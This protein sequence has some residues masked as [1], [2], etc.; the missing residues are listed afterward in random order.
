MSKIVVTGCAGFIGSHLVE[1]LLLQGREVIGIDNFHPYYQPSIKQNNIELALQSSKFEFHELS[2]LD[3]DKLV[4]VFD[5]AAIEQVVHLAALAGVRNSFDFPEEYFQINTIGTKNVFEAAI[6]CGV[7]HFI[8][9]SSSSVYGE[10]Q[11][12]KAVEDS[13]PLNPISPYA[14]SKVEAE[15]LIETLQNQYHFDVNILRFFTVYGARQRPD[16]A[17]QKFKKKILS[18]ETVELYGENMSRDF[19]PIEKIIEGIIAALDYK[20]GL[21]VFN[22]GSGKK[23]L[24]KSMILKIGKELGVEPKIKV[25]EQQKGDPSFTLASIKKAKK[26][27]N[28]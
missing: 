28:Y 18:G 2:I 8:F 24:V 19:T 25:V 23:V 27:L 13:T 12:E 10:M 9:A 7:K 1:K 4:E 15:K 16:M 3:K 14:Q 21:E 20:N 6:S 26:L 11:G 17:F 22:L 5:G